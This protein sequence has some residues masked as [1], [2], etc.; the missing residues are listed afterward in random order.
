[1][2]MAASGRR[3]SRKR[4]V[5]SS[6]KWV[7]SHSEPPLPQLM[8]LQPLRSAS[9]IVFTIASIVGRV[10]GEARKA[11]S[12][13]F[14]SRRLCSIICRFIFVSFYALAATDSAA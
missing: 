1:M 6:A 4:P 11:A 13:S 5:S 10:R 2:A 3:F 14:A 12:A 9:A 7:A 8:I